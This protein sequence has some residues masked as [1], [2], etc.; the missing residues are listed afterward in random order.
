MG[1]FIISLLSFFIVWIGFPTSNPQESFK[2][3][4][5]FAV[6]IFSGLAT[7]GAAIIAAHLFNDWREAE[8]H[9]RGL[10]LSDKLVKDLTSIHKLY[11]QLASQKPNSSITDRKQLANTI[12]EHFHELITF[13]SFALTEE[14]VKNNNIKALFEILKDARVSHRDYREELRACQPNQFQTV[15]DLAIKNNRFLSE[16]L[17]GLLLKNLNAVGIAK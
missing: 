11:T 12:N 16:S 15:D 9:K 7:F 17:D 4:L 10:E 8:D 1:I 13:T 14:L 3:S 6:G 5:G 2:D